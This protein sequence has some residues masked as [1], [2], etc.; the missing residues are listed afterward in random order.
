MDYIEEFTPHAEAIAEL[1]A[2][3]FTASEGAEEGALIGALAR[4]LI[5]ETPTENMRVV[6]AW[7]DG[8]LL[9]GIFFTRLT[10]AGDPRKVFITAPVAV[11]TAHQGKGIGQRMIAHGLDALRQE[12][13]DIAV[14]Y[15]DPAFYSRVGFKPVAEVD[16]PAPQP[17]QQPQGWIAQSL[18]DAPLT[19]LR[20]PARC[21]AVLDDPALW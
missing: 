7:E 9:G 20:G 8:A 13:V 10:Y 3:T 18:T 4:R 14:T 11:A 5:A 1:F 17:L 12:G 21:V 15:G 2:A 6:T 19:P 16:L